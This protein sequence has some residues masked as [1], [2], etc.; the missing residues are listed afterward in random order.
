MFELQI[1]STT[2]EEGSTVHF[3]TRVEPKNDPKLR[4]EWYRNGKPL[5]SGHRY[6]SLFDLGFVSLDVLAMYFDDSGEYLCRAV[7]D[8]GEAITKAMVT[9]KRMS[10]FYSCHL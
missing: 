8:H 3:E 5:P 10:I 4:I 7:N 2:V 6:Q 1:V 9:C